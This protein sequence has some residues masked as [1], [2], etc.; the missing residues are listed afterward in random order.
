MK[1]HMNGKN[2]KNWKRLLCLTLVLCMTFSMG[3]SYV[4]AGDDGINDTQQ[5]GGEGNVVPGSE[6]TSYSLDGGDGADITPS[7]EDVTPEGDQA[8][9]PGTNDSNIGDPNP[10]DPNE[11]ESPDTD[12]SNET[13]SQPQEDGAT[14]GSE[15]NGSPSVDAPSLP[16]VNG[17]PDNITPPSSNETPSE[18]TPATEPSESEPSEEDGEGQEGEEGEEG[19]GEEDEEEDQQGDGYTFDLYYVDQNDQNHVEK[20]EDF[21][22]KYQIQF[23]A[24]R[25]LAP[26]TVEIW[27]ERSL[28]DDRY[29]NSVVPADIAVPYVAGKDADPI[30]SGTSFNYYTVTKD[31]ERTV[32]N[33]NGETTKERVE[34]LV[35]FNYKEIESG[36]NVAW[37][38]LYK[39]IRMMDVIDLSEWS[40]TAKAYQEKKNDEGK[41][42]QNQVGDA[43][44][45]TGL[46]DSH[47]KVSS[48][49]KTEHSESGRKYA[50]VLYTRNQVERYISGPLPA[51]FDTN[52][53]DYVY[54]VWEVKA[55]GSANQPWN[56][57]VEE[58]PTV[59]GADG[60]VIQGQVVGFQKK[61]NATYS[62]DINDTPGA[63]TDGCYDITP[64]SADQN[65]KYCDEDS[66]SARFYVVTAYP[67][68]EVTSGVS[69]LE[70][71]IKVK[72]VPIDGTEEHRKEDSSEKEG[73]AKC[74]YQEY[75]WTYDGELLH[76]EKRSD[77]TDESAEQIEKAKYTGW[78]EL[79]AKS[80]DK[81]Y[82]GIPFRTRGYFEGYKLTH[83]IG[84]EDSREAHEPGQYIPGTAYEMTM[85]DDLMYVRV[86]NAGYAVPGSVKDR[87]QDGKGAMLQ[88]GDYYYTSVNITQEDL[89]YD[90]WEDA[91]TTPESLGDYYA[92]ENGNIKLTNGKLTAKDGSVV[93][94][95][96]NASQYLN[97]NVYIYAMYLV[98]GAKANEP[99][100]LVDSGELGEL[101]SH[102]WEYVAYVPWNASGKVTYAFNQDQLDRKPYRVM[103][104]HKT[105]NYRSVCNIDVEVFFP[106]TYND[107]ATTIATIQDDYENSD[108]YLN[109]QKPL[110]LTLEDLSGVMGTGYSN[111]VRDSGAYY[112]YGD[113][114]SSNSA[115]YDQPQYKDS[116]NNTLE[117]ASKTLYGSLP[118]R[119]N[120][121]KK[122]TGLTKEAKAFKKVA[123]SGNDATNE[124]VIVD[125]CLT[126]YDGY[127]IYN[128]EGMNYLQANK[129]TI[130]PS[131]DKVVFY[132]LLPSGMRFEGPGSVTAGR[133]K[134]F[135]S[136]G[137]YQSN[138]NLW[139]D[140]QVTVS[141]VDVE[142]NWR[143]TGRTMIAIHVN[144]S[145][146]DA[147]IY[148]NKLW[149]E[150][151]GV[152]FRA[153]YA[154][155]DR[156]TVE[157]GTNVAA[158]MPD[159]ASAKY[160]DE[161]CGMP[162]QVAMDN[163]SLDGLDMDE[164]EQRLYAALLTP[165]PKTT[166][167]GIDGDYR[168]KEV[169]NVLYAKDGT[170]DDFAI[171]SKTEILK[172]VSAD[173]DNATPGESAVVEKGKG[174]TYDITV[175][176]LQDSLS[177]IVV[178]DILENAHNDL[179]QTDDPK[180]QYEFE[181]DNTWQGT[182]RDVDVTT[183]K[184][185]GINAKVYYTNDPLDG[186]QLQQG[187]N[188]WSW[189]SGTNTADGDTSEP[190]AWTESVGEKA[191]AKLDSENRKAIKAIAVKMYVD[192]P[193]NPG[194]ETPYTLQ[195][196]DSLNFKIRMTAPENAP[197]EDKPAYA[198]NNPYYYAKMDVAQTG[199][200]LAG[201]PVKVA[202]SNYTSLIV[203]KKFGEDVPESFRDNVFRFQLY[204]Y[205]TSMNGEQVKK[206]IANKEYTIEKYVDGAW[207]PKEGLP[208]WTTGGGY[209]ELHA[210]ERA[211]FNGNLSH[212]DQIHVE[213]TKSIFWDAEEPQVPLPTGLTNVT[214]K[215]GEE[216]EI[217]AA[218]ATVTN[219]YR[220]VLYVQKRLSGVPEGMVD[221]E[222]ETF[223]FEIKVKRP[224]DT[225]YKGLTGKYY[226]TDRAYASETLEEAESLTDA[227]LGDGI[228]KIKKGQIV[229]LFPG[230]TGTEYIV[231][232]L[233]VLDEEGNLVSLEREDSLW[234]CS[235]KN[236]A[237]DGTIEDSETRAAITNYY[238]L[239]DLYLTKKI[240]EYQKAEDCTQEFTFTLYKLQKDGTEQLVTEP[241]VWELLDEDGKP[242]NP[243]GTQENEGTDP[244]TS[245]ETP[246]DEE[247][248]ASQENQDTTETQAPPATS[249]R[250]ENGSFT[251]AFAGKTVRIRGLKVEPGETVAS[252]IIRET[253]SGED[254]RPDNDSELVKIDYRNDKVSKSFL[255]HYLRRPLSV[256]KVV[257][258]D[259]EGATEEQRKAVADREF[260][261]KVM[262]NGEP[263]ANWPYTLTEGGQE[264][265]EG[266]AGEIPGEIPGGILGG[267][268]GS[269]MMSFPDDATVEN[270]EGNLEQMPEETPKERKTTNENGEFTLKNGQTATFEG[271][272]KPGEE[273][274]VWEVLDEEYR[275][276][277][278]NKNATDEAGVTK[279]GLV[280][281]DADSYYVKQFDDETNRIFCAPYVDVISE[282]GASA[283][284][285]NGAGEY[286]MLRKEYVGVGE[287]GVRFV[288]VMK[289]AFTDDTRQKGQY[290][291]FKVNL[292][293]KLKKEDGTTVEWPEARKS[294]KLATLKADGSL[295][296][297]I[298]WFGKGY[299]F[300]GADGNH[301]EADGS[302]EVDPWVTILIPIDKLPE[303]TTGYILSEAEENQKWNDILQLQSG[304]GM[305]PQGNQG[306]SGDLSLMSWANEEPS[307]GLNLV[308]EDVGVPEL[309]DPSL[310]LC[311]IIQGN[312]QN[313]LSTYVQ[314]TQQTPANFGALEA[315]MDNK[316]AVI[317]NQVE[318][319]PMS[320]SRIGKWMAV[321]SNPVPEGAKLV[322][323]LQKYTGSTWVPAAGVKYL[324]FEG[325]GNAGNLTTDRMLETDGQGRIVLEKTA[326][327]YPSVQFQTARAYLNLY[328]AE[329]VTKFLGELEKVPD[330]APAE[331]RTLYRIIELPAD[332]EY[333]TQGWGM[334]V[335]YIKNMQDAESD[336]R[337]SDM[338]DVMVEYDKKDFGTSEGMN[339]SEEDTG[340]S[341]MLRTASRKAI[342]KSMVSNKALGSGDILDSGHEID[343]TIYDGY[344]TDGVNRECYSK[345]L[346]PTDNGAFVN[347]NR[348]DVVEIEKKMETGLGNRFTMLLEQVVS[349]QQV[350]SGEKVSEIY[351][352]SPVPGIPY[353]LYSSATNQEMG[354]GRTGSN[355]EIYLHPGQYAKLEL[356]VQ[357]QWIVSEKEA[358]GHG[359][360]M[361]LTPGQNQ[362][363]NKL[364]KL[365]D[366]EML[367]TM[368]AEKV[369]AKLVATYKGDTNDL[370]EGG[371]LSEKK[372]DEVKKE[373]FEFTLHYSDLS[374]MPL[375]NEAQNLVMQEY[376]P[377]LSDGALG[378]SSVIFEFT[379]GDL[380]AEVVLSSRKHDSSG[381]DRDDALQGLE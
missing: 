23:H 313:K 217:N 174:Y 17:N 299:D 336:I 126:A 330:T 140:T 230:E 219:T 366:N 275:Q 265:Q 380:K 183:L 21:N 347:S 207:T 308:S 137:K 322:W 371:F 109:S 332:R 167:G 103:V 314:V 188:L 28:F 80:G 134:D 139:S 343:R 247:N 27:I 245:P 44:T 194:S 92:L 360:T 97:E 335:G 233:G 218:Y 365:A 66:W 153:Y 186:N 195:K 7:L 225:E 286:L 11:S 272:G 192:D 196:G 350:E 254:Y 171:M 345:S 316:L 177:D 94:G 362:E 340:D 210:G 151:W 363:G 373:D 248:T 252:Y 351:E 52:F 369:P 361:E 341:S 232:E 84:A 206:A 223:V 317:C 216:V 255:N 131:R 266:A 258:Y 333:D 315:T 46:A 40:L 250:L 329:E 41:T 203:E 303:G 22:L 127:Q 61:M 162:G 8:S 220:P 267:N 268:S 110:A 34:Y 179:A 227:A 65:K 83:Y 16:G 368:T 208:Q 356:P 143:D 249:G 129:A 113:G 326:N 231:K 64:V 91:T 375:G 281:L 104:V 138:P 51:E 78:L 108:I 240:D 142:N 55:S 312:I 189:I 70:N 39:N 135:D 339:P 156:K 355:G 74:T 370:L 59:K 378:F 212:A 297:E 377:I 187:G 287:D 68:A 82:G 100:G 323:Q 280:T 132:D 352:T 102:G 107:V 42:E 89:G 239:K 357:T 106:R 6:I 49:G 112:Q 15:D 29:G 10:E 161:L 2:K 372:L 13:P 147:T 246:E 178:V 311:A 47:V 5:P 53:D 87:V 222:E 182:I 69:V 3:S 221:Q 154:W 359:Y 163:G 73:S 277:Y 197:A 19:E 176:Q 105:I 291:K 321:G 67:K 302:I 327:G 274:E 32:K 271:A 85:V 364:R 283:T 215:Q 150:G 166:E 119:D 36:T 288:E 238:R 211:V 198:Y 33:A 229:A 43:I 122:V 141:Q 358:V 88:K 282:E 130:S 331:A 58:N 319:F 164:A 205:E 9:Q 374:S 148:S 146:A 149:A 190:I 63:P 57:L 300:I 1:L 348:T 75:V 201:N 353:T 90:M 114:S 111:G 235:A 98:D 71:S 213:E 99:A 307:G 169:A 301:Y 209:L 30:P 263:L 304:Q 367:I 290:L 338:G 116:T 285:L 128:Q 214:N 79:Y 273:F 121:V 117:N 120:A 253:N 170:Y 256:T 200:T 4:S 125:Y 62:L 305:L 165:D 38:V 45:L 81:G 115:N 76:I 242:V 172:R 168:N 237:V 325:V 118:C 158:F 294:E 270:P 226:L 228:F 191:I 35:F 251:C 289:K 199:A 236:N 60:T 144:Y 309:N 18:E 224:G 86:D 310:M 93:D 306:P 157:A 155:E 349:R 77:E 133:I 56:L 295:G 278:S 296:E 124:R 337:D 381:S 123:N 136:K 185:M 14:G 318:V 24:K 145:G 202:L 50:P 204:R 25:K 376:R 54:A 95:S 259:F 260:T 152:S 20:T 379:Y 262:V 234:I 160:T 96:E 334:L 269:R 193:E 342:N 279:Y 241:L 257:T 284:I 320:G 181:K 72:M 328:K 244:Q 346:S 159:T 354:E 184:S 292:S 180:L 12:N 293:L 173:S 324:S 31:E 48:V 26:K 175:R 243:V 298:N 37:Q 276:I 261:M 344:A 101:R 264:V